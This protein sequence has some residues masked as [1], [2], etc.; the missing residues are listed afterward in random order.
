MLEEPSSENWLRYYVASVNTREHVPLTSLLGIGHSNGQARAI[1]RIYHPFYKLS[2]QDGQDKIQLSQNLFKIREDDN[3]WQ[4]GWRKDSLIDGLGQFYL[5]IAG[6]GSIS[7]GPH[8]TMI[9]SWI[10]HVIDLHLDNQESNHGGRFIRSGTES[11]PYV[12]K[13]DP[14]TD[15]PPPRRHSI[16]DIPYHD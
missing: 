1:P 11:L 2:T 16:H 9:I 15:S 14:P 8:L 4:R 5:G 12:D 7:K 6:A 10:Y 3:T 13:R